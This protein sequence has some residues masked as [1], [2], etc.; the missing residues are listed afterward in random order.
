MKLCAIFIVWD[1]LE[2]LPFAIKNVRPHVDSVII[3]W[4]KYSNKGNAGDFNPDDYKDCY[5]VNWEPDLKLQ[6]HD[7]ERAKRNR[8]LEVARELGFTHFLMMDCDEFYD[9]IEFEREKQRIIDHDLNGLVCGTQVY[10]KEPTLTIGL[11]PITFV[12]FIHKLKDTTRFVLNKY[13]PFSYDKAGVNHIDP[14]RKMNYST[15]VEWSDMIMHHYSHVRKDLR[16]K[17]ENSSSDRLKKS[18]LYSEWLNAKEGD[19]C[20]WYGMTLVSCDNKF[21]I[22]I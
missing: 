20:S 9:P 5:R 2:L 10:F 19:F 15:G 17:I 22:Q 13:Y 8:G 6:S 18:S 14:T 21:G 16:V 1:G 3:I 7:N 12:P 11:D 4:S